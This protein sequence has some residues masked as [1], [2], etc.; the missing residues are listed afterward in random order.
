MVSFFLEHGCVYDQQV[1][2]WHAF[3]WHIVSME[4]GLGNSRFRIRFLILFEMVQLISQVAM[5]ERA[6]MVPRW[7]KNCTANRIPWSQ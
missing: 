1:S 2:G 4:T 6:S 3:F 7:M 5:A